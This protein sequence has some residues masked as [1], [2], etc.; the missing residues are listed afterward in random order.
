M[1]D[2]IIRLME[3]IFCRYRQE[4]IPVNGDLKAALK[5]LMIRN[6]IIQAKIQLSLIA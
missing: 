6:S 5:I 2:P 1:K 3:L 4:L